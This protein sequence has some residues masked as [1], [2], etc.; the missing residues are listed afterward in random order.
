MREMAFG[1]KRFFKLPG[2][3]WMGG[4]SE[5]VFCLFPWLPLSV[6]SLLKLLSADVLFHILLFPTITN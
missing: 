1:K 5:G 3:E 4:E 2:E 6:N